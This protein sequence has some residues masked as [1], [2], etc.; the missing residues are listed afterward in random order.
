MSESIDNLNGKEGSAGRRR[1]GKKAVLLTAVVLCVLVLL[2][3]GAAVWGY[4][5]SVSDRNLPRV[6]I[7]GI[8]VGGMT[9]AESAAA[10]RDAHWGE[11]V[12]GTLSVTLPAGAGFS[13]DTIRSGAVITAEQ[14]VA[15]AQ[16]YGHTGDVFGN[17]FRYLANHL[18]AHDVVQG[19]RT[20]DEAYLRSCIDEGLT[21]LRRNLAKSTFTADLPGGKLLV[22]KGAGG[23]ELDTDALYDEVCA[24]LRGGKDT[25]VFDKL[26][27]E[28]AMPDFEKLYRDLSTEPAD[29]RFR[30]DFSIEPEVVGCSFGV[31]QAAAL[32]KQAAVGEQVVI[33]LT[34]RQPE[35]TA[36]DLE[37]LLYRDV[38]GVQTTS[39]AWSSDSRINNINL[40][41]GKLNGVILLPGDTFS[42]N[43][44]VGQRTA[45]AGF[46]YAKAYSD[47]EEV[48]AL[49]G[50]ICQVSST[51]YCATMYAQLKT[52][53]RTN[54]YFKVSYLDYGLDATVSWG[55]PDFK[56]RNSRDYPI[57]I[58][59]YLNPDEQTL[60][61]EIWGTDTDGSSIR[62]RHT[63]AEVFDEEYPEVV[64]G[65][66]VYTYGDVYDINGNYIDTVFENSGTY[67][68]HK[69]D[70]E[71]PEGHE[72]PFADSF[73]H[74]YLNPT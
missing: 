43:E 14:A 47:G 59:A 52:V 12:P 13:V 67:F 44:T 74:D 7:D 19:E 56:F 70:I 61:V 38:L 3:S 51:L 32:W 5:L 66:S 17:L 48:E 6:Y 15:A 39:Y 29:A 65:H 42:Y 50:G 68:L 40:A 21:R 72:D 31:E 2:L 73:M 23:V 33:P 49:G 22:L 28:P 27:Q 26:K 34:L 54:H 20:L 16:R 4:M 25:L 1:R 53:S 46:R 11:D 62:L 63:S 8:F 41:A 60:T 57:M 9:E 69:E 24:A 58:Q 45:E 35:V 18:T 10:L 37:K 30:E 64:I 55:Q 36:A 71:W